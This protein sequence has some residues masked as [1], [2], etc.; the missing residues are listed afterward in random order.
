MYTGLG[1]YT[2]AHVKSASLWY[3]KSFRSTKNLKEG[4]KERGERLVNYLLQ[5]VLVRLLAHEFQEI[6]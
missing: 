6:R 2:R 3:D 5:M 1:D 4:Y